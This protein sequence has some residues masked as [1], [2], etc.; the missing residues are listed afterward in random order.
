MATRRA[1]LISG[2]GDE[3]SDT[4]LKGVFVD[5]RNYERH[6]LSPQGGAWDKQEL[7][8]LHSPFASDVRRWLQDN[9]HHDYTFIMYTGHGAYT[10]ANND[11]IL[12][13][14]PGQRMLGEELR[15]TS[16][17]RT[18][19]MDSCQVY[20]RIFYR[21]DLAEAALN[22]AMQKR[23]P[24]RER[25]RRKFFEDVSGAPNAVV[26]LHSCSKGES[27]YEDDETGGY[28]NSSVIASIDEWV[29]HQTNVNDSP[30][31]MSGI[32]AHMAATPKT[33]ARSQDRQH[34]VIVQR[35]KS[36]LVFP[37]AV[38]A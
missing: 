36:G 22:A 19:I 8:T 25:C 17:R 20:E 16:Q 26:A 15:S 14:R 2:P 24:D 1:L 3:N 29:R 13:L 12:D 28:Y 7:T 38:F 11:Q 32:A 5:I 9:K 34:P 10:T 27:A 6:L 33:V 35:P 4:Y 23:A 31:A 18:V 30:T 37:I 21:A